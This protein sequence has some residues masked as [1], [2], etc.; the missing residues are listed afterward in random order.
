MTLRLL[1]ILSVPWAGENLSKR[2]LANCNNS[3][4]IKLLPCRFTSKKT[5]DWGDFEKSSYSK[6]AEDDWAL[7]KPKPR[8]D[9]DWSAPVSKSTRPSRPAAS[10]DYS[11]GVGDEAQKK[12]GN[13][14]AIS[15]DQFFGGGKDNDV[16]EIALCVRVL[17]SI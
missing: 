2:F 17:N 4:Q 11:S 14:K 5:A 8:Q 13:A 16:S 6:P 12:F 3:V 9:D 7:L 15:S 1:I 10:G